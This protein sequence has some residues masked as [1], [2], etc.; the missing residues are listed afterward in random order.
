MNRTKTFFVGATAVIA[1]LA[2]AGCADTSTSD[3]SSGSSAASEAA[4]FNDQDVMFAQMML[5]HHEQ[6]VE[7]SD[8]LISKGDTVDS[9]VLALAETIKDEQ[10]PEIDQL[11]TWLGDWGQDTSASMDHSMDGMMSESDM[12]S[13][14]DASGTEASRLFLEQ[15]TEHHK[16]AVDMAQQEVDGGEN[17]DA[18]EMAKNIVESQTAQIDQMD[19]LLSSL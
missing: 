5:P 13:L 12:T 2:L 8:T 15:M 6:A 16:G 17:P 18:V 19:S 11:T 1:A 14:E 4:V 9:D 7:M 10:G 3:T